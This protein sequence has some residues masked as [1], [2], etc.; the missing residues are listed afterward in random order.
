MNLLATTVVCLLL[1]LGLSACTASPV[2]ITAARP[3]PADPRLLGTWRATLNEGE[4]GD[5]VEDEGIH[6]VSALPNGRLL[7]TEKP[8]HPDSAPEEFE[9]ITADIAG[10]LYGSA[11]AH[12]HEG[13]PP[14]YLV[15]RYEHESPDRVQLYIALL[16]TL[17]EAVRLKRITGKR[18]P[19]RH[20]D[21]FELESGAEDLRAF[22]RKHGKQVF[23]WKGPVLERVR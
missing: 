11:T 19:D 22:V 13:K 7:V 23:S 10:G 2:P 20:L 9:V 15:F 12:D 17:E 3:Q 4:P 21:F 1:M 14:R 18:V 5:E 16:E 6:I 8:R